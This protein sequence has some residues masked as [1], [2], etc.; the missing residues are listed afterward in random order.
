MLRLDT[1]EIAKKIIMYIMIAVL[2]V[3]VIPVIPVEVK[4]DEF[5]TSISGFPESYKPY[6][7]ALHAKYPNWVFKPYNTG[8][9]FSTAVARSF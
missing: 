4:A 5:E 8:L 6:L 3:S 9:D 7:R 1:R 2:I